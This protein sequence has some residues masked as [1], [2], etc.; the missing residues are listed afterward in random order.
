MQVRVVQEHRAE[1]PDLGRADPAADL[2]VIEL[3]QLA[4]RSGEL[5]VLI[6]LAL[7]AVGHRPVRSA[8]QSGARCRGGRGPAP[9]AAPRRARR[10][11]LG[12]QP[13]GMGRGNV[14]LGVQRFPGAARRGHLECHHQCVAD[15]R[16]GLKPAG[17]RN[18]R[19]PVAAS[20]GGQPAAGRADDATSADGAGS[21][22]HGERLLGVAGVAGAQDG[23]VRRRP[24]R[25]PVAA[26]DHDRTRGTVAER[27]PG[28]RPADCR[29]PH[30]GHDQTGRE[31]W[32]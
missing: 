1:A 29:P 12:D 23:G 21:F 19:H 32:R 3:R 7:P 17:Q 27:G 14:D 25:Q 9:W 11:P 5:G 22:E 15:R 31:S 13:L 8:P 30:P 20:V 24:P 26:A 2:V 16:A 28:E 10:P 18:H 4:G 6:D